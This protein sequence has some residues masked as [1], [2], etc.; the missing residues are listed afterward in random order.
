MHQGPAPQRTTGAGPQVASRAM[1]LSSDNDSDDGAPVPP[2]FKCLDA[3]PTKP[4]MPVALSAGACLMEPTGHN[5]WLLRMGTD[6]PNFLFATG[7]GRI[8][9]YNFNVVRSY[10]HP[11]HVHRRASAVRGD[12]SD[13]LELT[14]EGAMMGRTV[15]GWRVVLACTGSSLYGKQP[16]GHT[17]TIA[18]GV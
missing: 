9:S 12:Y 5:E 18:N 3:S 11:T 6:V 8:T 14:D 1:P 2:N 17:M 10:Y 4:V 16:L 7:P 13:I 15:C